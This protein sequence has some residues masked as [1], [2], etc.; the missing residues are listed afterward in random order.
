MIANGLLLILN[1]PCTGNDDYSS[2]VKLEPDYISD[3][4]INS[5]LSHATIATYLPPSARAYSSPQAVHLDL[6]LPVSPQLGDFFLKVFL[7]QM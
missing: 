3:K 2:H 7:C 1:V 4:V 6:D 5:K